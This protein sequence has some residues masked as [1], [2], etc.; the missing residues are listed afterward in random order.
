MNFSKGKLYEKKNIGHTNALITIH[1]TWI[2]YVYIEMVQYLI[3]LKCL[4]I[5]CKI[6]CLE[7]R[8]IYLLQKLSANLIYKKNF[9]CNKIL[10]DRKSFFNKKYTIYN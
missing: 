4:Q 8:M 5:S 7:N 10:K 9:I 6:K 2:K 1:S 3:H